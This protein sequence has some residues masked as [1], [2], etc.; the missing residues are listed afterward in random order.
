MRELFPKNN[1]EKGE[2]KMIKKMCGIGI[3]AM[4]AVTCMAVPAF[5]DDATTIDFWYHDGNDVSNAYW[6]EIIAKFEEKYPEY[7]VNYT[8]LPAESYMTKYTTAIATGTA[9]DVVDLRDTDI[10]TM[11]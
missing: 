1:K 6:Q 2:R 8:G 9:P 10:A 4:A 3:A 5:A 11:V 7:K